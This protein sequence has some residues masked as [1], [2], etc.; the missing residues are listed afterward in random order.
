MSDLRASAVLHRPTLALDARV[1]LVVVVDGPL[2]VHTF[3]AEVVDELRARE[4]RTRVET[5]RADGHVVNDT[6]LVHDLVERVKLHSESCRIPH[7]TTT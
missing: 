6:E 3:G 7:D 2:H 1:G 4:L 5:D